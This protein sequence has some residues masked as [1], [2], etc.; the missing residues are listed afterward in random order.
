M[1]R[2]TFAILIGLLLI[3]VLGACSPQAPIVSAN[4]AAADPY[5]PVPQM[6]ANGQGVVY[7][8]P[9]VAYVSIGVQTSADNVSAALND[10]NAQASAIANTLKEMGV[11]EKDI[12]TSAF[13]VYPQQDYAP[14]GTPMA[15]KYVVNNTV[16]VTVRDLNNMGQ[17]L[18][19]GRPLR[20]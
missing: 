19:L 5:R 1:K 17:L 9:D 6:T 15:M 14:D 13:S 4:P 2:N 3:T 18:E 20:R 8:T 12:Q 10:N 7:L 16:Y 11:A